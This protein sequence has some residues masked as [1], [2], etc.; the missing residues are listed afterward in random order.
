LRFADVAAWANVPVGT[1]I[2]IF[3]GADN[4]YGFTVNES[5]TG[6]YFIN[7]NSTSLIQRTGSGATPNGS[8]GNCGYCGNSYTATGAT[9]WAS[10][11][12]LGNTADAIQVRCPD[13][14]A[15]EA[16]FFH[17]VGYGGSTFDEVNA[18]T[19]DLGGAHFSGNG[20]GRT[21]EL[22]GTGCGTLGDATG[23]TRTNA[24]ASG[25][26]P[27]TAG[28]VGAGVLA[29]LEGCEVPCCGSFEPPVVVQKHGYRYG[30]Q[31]Q[32]KDDEM[33]GA[34]GT[35]YDFGA[36]IYDPRVGRWLS[37]D[38]L[39]KKYSDLSPYCFVGNNPIAFVD[40]NG[41][42]IVIHYGD[43]QSYTYG[44]NQPV[45][46]DAF[47]M[48]TVLALNHLIANAQEP[49]R[50][51]ESMAISNQF[52]W[53]I[54][55]GNATQGANDVYTV[56]FGAGN[57]AF[58]T[59]DPRAGVRT[60]SGGV[61]SLAT[62]LLHEGGHAW[63][64]SMRSEIIRAASKLASEAETAEGSQ[65]ILDDATKTLNAID[66]LMNTQIGEWDEIEERYVI[67]KFETPYARSQG[68]G[69]R[70]NHRGSFF[71]TD[72]PTSTTPQASSVERERPTGAPYAD[73][74]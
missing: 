74:P 39:A 22:T 2:V 38:P 58:T 30:F 45:P 63:L 5:G 51:V 29:W 67:E 1:V 34:T 70:D 71:R 27:A 46:D 62:Q 6:P 20:T 42:E 28:V 60:T 66:M 65:R 57:T 9:A 49:E 36:R 25:T 21:Y 64:A 19:N 33:H 3:N 23:W 15:S 55:Q 68:E 54:G 7:V 35:S 11:M 48:E 41:K 31:G 14:P 53:S 61:Q 56:P 17:G 40:P 24:P 12:G 69:V 43:N 32:E 13:C 72:S 50:I 47:V 37:L 52:T 44:S 73:E 59:W 26:P 16:G 4:C 8:G 18:G 10:V